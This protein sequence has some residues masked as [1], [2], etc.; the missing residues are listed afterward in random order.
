[1]DLAYTPYARARREGKRI[2]PLT[3]EAEVRFANAASRASV[4]VSPCRPAL[5]AA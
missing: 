5:E 2:A 4:I 3:L 1:M